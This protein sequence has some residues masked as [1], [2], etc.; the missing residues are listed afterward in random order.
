MHKKIKIAVLGIGGVGGY[1]G[2]LL[3]KEYEHSDKIEIYFIARGANETA[4]KSKGINLQTPKEHFIAYPKLTSSDPR[5]IGPVDFLICC[6]KT[7]DLEQSIY[8]MMPCINRKT[9]ILSLL[10]GIDCAEKIKQICP[11][12]EV[13]DGGAYLVSNL[14]EPGIVKK[15]SDIGKLFFG[16]PEGF[17]NKQMLLENILTEAGIDTTLSKEI[18]AAMWEKFF[19][20]S[21]MATL[22]SFLNIPIG[23]ILSTTR[24]KDLLQSLMTELKSLADAKNINISDNIIQMTLDKLLS[25]PYEATS[26]MHRDFQKGKQTEVDAL[27]GYVVKMGQQLNIPT[28]V[29]AM[30]YET[31]KKMDGKLK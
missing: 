19:M 21:T 29:Y 17:T 14:T 23:A 16:A 30:M 25:L 5:E 13:L 6:I 1:F 8:Q 3:A 22:T 4:L 12:N 20:I 28:P 24:N 15:T 18:Q 31:L 27:T 2:G 10:N 11:V 7:Y 9:V 26:S